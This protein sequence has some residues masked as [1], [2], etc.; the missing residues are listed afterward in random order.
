MTS[1]RSSKLP[2]TSSR[3]STVRELA[4]S[5]EGVAGWKAVA[6]C[7]LIFYRDPTAG[8]LHPVDGDPTSPAHAH[9]GRDGVLALDF[10]RVGFPASG[11]QP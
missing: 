11:G 10:A 5:A 4:A 9:E 7:G 6:C 2:S 3:E 8:R 1:P